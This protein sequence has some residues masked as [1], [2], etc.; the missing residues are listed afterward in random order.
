MPIHLQRFFHLGQLI[1][2]HT[3]KFVLRRAQL[4]LEDNT[5]IVNQRGDSRRN[6]NLLVFNTECFRHNKCGGAH[7]RR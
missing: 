3:V 1:F 6:D 5:Q 2:R 4:N 7:N